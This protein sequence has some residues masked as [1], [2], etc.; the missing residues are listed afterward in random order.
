MG[1]GAGRNKLGARS[2]AAHPSPIFIP[3]RTTIPLPTKE[4]TESHQPPGTSAAYKPSGTIILPACRGWPYRAF[5]PHIACGV[6]EICSL[7]EQ[8]HSDLPTTGQ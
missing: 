7:R 8:I 5:P 6:I 2:P 1:G 4:A 3:V